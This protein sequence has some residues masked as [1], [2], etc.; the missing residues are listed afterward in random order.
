MKPPELVVVLGSHR[1][2]TSATT[3]ALA[4][5]GLA[6]GEHLQPADEYNPHGYYEDKRMV[7]LNNKLFAGRDS[8]WYRPWKVR[9][10]AP[11]AA[12][13]ESV[14]QLQKQFGSEGIQVLKDPRLCVLLPWWRD[15]WPS[16]TLFIHIFRH[17]TETAESLQR[18]YGWSI[19]FG[20]LLWI[21]QI[22][23]QLRDTRG[24]TNLYLLD[25]EM[26]SDPARHMGRLA[27]A[28]DS[29][30]PLPANIDPKLRHHKATG[31]CLIPAAEQL[32]QHVQRLA[33][34]AGSLQQQY[35]GIEDFCIELA[36]AEANRMRSDLATEKLLSQIEAELKYQA[37]KLTPSTTS[38]IANKL[39]ELHRFDAI[40]K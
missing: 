36:E 29:D 32:W 28:I 6:T 9:N 4:E 17:P 1:S 21:E 19:A 35:P 7:V 18:R 14:R 20:E 26:L 10:L 13:I 38:D 33:H 27:A 31:T 30:L 37:V 11:S 5:L 34:A 39:A 3:A 25:S 40:G 2:G 12:E 22:S 23:A 16:S 24:A 15:G 8:A